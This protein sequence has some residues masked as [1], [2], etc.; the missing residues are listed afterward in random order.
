MRDVIFLA[1]VILLTGCSA[2]SVATLRVEFRDAQLGEG[3]FFNEPPFAI[4]LSPDGSQVATGRTT[5]NSVE[6]RD[7][8]DATRILRKLGL[9]NRTGTE[10]GGLRYSP[11]GRWLVAIN[12]ADTFAHIWK[13]E[14]GELV[15]TIPG[16]S[17]GPLQHASVEF[18]PDG[19]TLVA[20]NN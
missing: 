1:L 8:K 9:G 16:L 17:E 12:G 3:S 10:I 18:S 6:I 13:A 4:A 15:T 5:V 11:D 2:H 7:W 14:T 19:R 20:C